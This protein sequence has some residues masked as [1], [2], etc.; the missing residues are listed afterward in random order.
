MDYAGATLRE[1]TVYRMCIQAATALSS[2]FR[3][4]EFACT[5]GTDVLLVHPALVDLLEAIR[6]EIGEAIHITNAFRTGAHND[7]VGGADRSAHLDGFAADIYAENTSPEEIARVADELGAG[8]VGLYND[9]THVD[10]AGAGRRW[11]SR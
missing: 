5:D 1:S 3:V 6:E 2:H 10:V 4:R 7:A 9:F 11:D 8:G